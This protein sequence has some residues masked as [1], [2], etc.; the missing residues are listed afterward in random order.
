MWRRT[1]SLSLV[2]LLAGVSSEEFAGSLPLLSNEAQAKPGGGKGG[3]GNGGSGGG[4]GRHSTS[5][6]KG[7]SRAGAHA[8]SSRG[9]PAPGVSRRAVDSASGAVPGRSVSVPAK[10]RREARARKDRWARQMPALDKQRQAPGRNAPREILVSTRDAAALAGLTAFGIQPI[11]V[12]SLRTSTLV[13]LG[14]PN[15]LSPEAAVQLVSKAAHGSIVSPNA[16]YYPA[17][18]SGCA[19][20]EDQ[21]E[22]VAAATAGC[23]I[24]ATIGLI[25]TQIDLLHPALQGRDIRILKSREGAGSSTAHGSA[26][27]ALLVGLPARGPHGLLPR[28]TLL[29]TDAFTTDE[30]GDYTDAFALAAALDTLV[31]AGADVINL[32]LA[33]PENDVLRAAVANA[34]QQGVELVASVGNTSG[35]ARAYPAAY[36]EVISVTAVDGRKDVYRYANSGP[37]V[38]FAAPGVAVPIPGEDAVQMSGTSFAAPAITAAVAML[39]SNPDRTSTPAEL[40]QKAAVDL[41]EPG[42]DDVFGWGMIDPAAICPRPIP[43]AESP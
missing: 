15:H 40:L 14:I 36:P 4:K 3:G 20:C 23:E 7:S 33:G 12:R 21:P 8:R 29:A 25:D 31:A 5:A 28:S 42:R 22:P 2:I 10:Q 26:M 13:K 27:A 30:H 35:G 38:D 18:H 32:S 1:L 16:Y 11:A 6:S 39:R 24:A 34:V 43:I 19:D 9:V 37:F 41:G 17:H